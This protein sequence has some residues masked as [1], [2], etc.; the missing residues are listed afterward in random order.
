AAMEEGGAAARALREGGAPP[1]ALLHCLSAY[2]APAGEVN[3]RAM[4]ALSARFGCPVGYSDHTLGVDIAVAAV[5]RGA[6]IIEKH[7]TL[8]TSLPRPD[9]PPSPPPPAF[10][11][12]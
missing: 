9:H 6:C 7:L 3:L 8:D 4:D 10:P 2:P 1:L 5:A 12:I 11:P